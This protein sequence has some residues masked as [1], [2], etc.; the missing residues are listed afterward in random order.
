MTDPKTS[1]EIKRMAAAIM[2]IATTCTVEA[3]SAT[4][5]LTPTDNDWH[6]AANWTPAT[7]PNGDSDTATFGVSNTTAIK[8]GKYGHGTNGLVT[9]VDSLVFEAGASSYSI[10]VVPRGVYGLALELVGRR[11]NQ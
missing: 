1:A 10:T 7:V 4:W 11:G 8:V 2:L 3:G 5:N 9:A 6:N